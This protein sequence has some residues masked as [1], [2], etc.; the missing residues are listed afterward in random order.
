MFICV[1]VPWLCKYSQTAGEVC[2]IVFEV[3]F[4]FFDHMIGSGS[5]HMPR[6]IFKFKM[7]S[8]FLVFNGKV[9]LELI[10][11]CSHVFHLSKRV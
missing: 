2:M 3:C 10:T 7:L 8:F 5:C 9:T 4:S 11:F 1:R 6:S